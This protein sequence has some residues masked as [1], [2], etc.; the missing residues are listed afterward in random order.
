MASGFFVNYAVPLPKYWVHP[1]LTEADPTSEPVL[2][3]S[4]CGKLTAKET[5]ESLRSVVLFTR[6]P[7]RCI[8][9][10]DW[11]ATKVLKELRGTMPPHIRFQIVRLHKPIPWMLRPSLYKL[12]HLPCTWQRLYLPDIVPD[13][14]FALYVDTDTLFFADLKEAWEDFKSLGPS[15]IMSIALEE[16]NTSQHS[17]YQVMRH[18]P[19]YGQTGLAAGVMFF[20][21]EKMRRSGWVD[22]VE[23]I[24]VN[25]N[26]FL[27]IFDQ[28]VINIYGH[29]HPEAI[30]IVTCRWNY[31]V[32]HCLVKDN[33]CPSAEQKGIG[34]LHGV[35]DA[36]KTSKIPEF[37]AAFKVIQEWD[38]RERDVITMA[39]E[40]DRQIARL[41]HCP[42]ST[43]DPNGLQIFSKAFRMNVSHVTHVV[44][45]VHRLSNPS[46]SYQTPGE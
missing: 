46:C 38:L 23:E 14:Q 6:V 37:S 31:R 39:D 13:V 5:L 19:F 30:N 32:N 34:I 44:P 45:I 1:T 15:H 16:E 28:D 26:A 43:C 17:S 20:D 40:M 27:K 21:L 18:V 8:V 7:F 4:A 25:Y 22:E 2:I 11:I 29:R 35:V 10:A 12:A 9:V 33:R 42:I 36:F 3:F 24:L 41:I